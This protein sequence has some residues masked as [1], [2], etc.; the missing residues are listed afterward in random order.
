MKTNKISENM[1]Y[2]KT[3]KCSISALANEV[4]CVN[5]LITQKCGDLISGSDRVHFYSFGGGGGGGGIGWLEEEGGSKGHSNISLLKCHSI[6]FIWVISITVPLKALFYFP[7]SRHPSKV[8][9]TLSTSSNITANP[10]LPRLLSHIS[11]FLCVLY[12]TSRD[13]KKGSV[14]SKSIQ[15]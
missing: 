3:I 5:R 14:S 13:H 15:L 11:L 6:F 2:E 4:V 7:K 1:N 9:P 12:S 8:L 10:P